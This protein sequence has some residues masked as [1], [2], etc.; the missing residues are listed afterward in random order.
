[1][2]KLTFSVCCFSRAHNRFCTDW[3]QVQH[4]RDQ[5]GVLVELE[6][7]FAWVQKCKSR[8]GAWETT[9]H[10]LHPFTRTAKEKMQ[11]KND[12]SIFIS[13]GHNRLRGS[14]RRVCRKVRTGG[15]Q[16]G[17]AQIPL[18]ERRR[19]E[20]ALDAQIP[21]LSVLRPSR[22]EPANNKM[23]L[24]VIKSEFNI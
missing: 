20:G 4:P 10:V 15:D 1:V 6:T 8:I 7:I 21:L 11:A 3:A 5:P 14:V 13:C 24:K 9:K 17:K 23:D 19:G 16:G 12:F 2:H 18:G 22:I